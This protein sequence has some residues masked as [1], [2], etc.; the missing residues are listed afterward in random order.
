VFPDS[1]D[2]LDVM[3]CLAYGVFP[4]HR[5]RKVTQARTGSKEKL[6]SLVVRATRGARETWDR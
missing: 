2:Q 5:D 4:D 3:D 6:D 1:L